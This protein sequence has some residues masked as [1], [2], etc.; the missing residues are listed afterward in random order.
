M[1]DDTERTDDTGEQFFS[2]LFQ[3]S[4]IMM[5]LFGVEDRTFAG[6]NDAFVLRL[7]YLPEEVVG[8]SMSTLGI[9]SVDFERELFAT[10]ATDGRVRDLETRMR[11]KTGEEIITLSSMDV[12]DNKGKTLILWFAVDVT[13][14]VRLR[15]M[16]EANSRELVRSNAELEQFAYVAS[17]DLQEPIRVVTSYLQIIGTQ[18]GAAMDAKGRD[19]I[20]RSIDAANRMQAMI[21]SLLMYSRISSERRPFS[22]IDSAV[23]AQHA[24]QNLCKAIE[25]K[26]ATVRI[27][28]LPKIVA[29]ES[30]FER[31][32]Q[33][34]I[35]NA[36][37]F[38]DKQNPMVLVSATQQSGTTVFSVQDNGLGIEEK[39]FGRIFEIFQRLHSRS[40][41]EGTGIGLAACKKIVERHHGKIWV[42][43]ALGKGSTFYFRLGGVG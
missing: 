31:L 1:I 20:G 23:I 34:L 36:I 28:D 13:E 10:L 25:E 5:S 21:Q 24:V 29:D 37:K 22:T 38:C 12:L 14:T 3:C 30:Q 33:N 43:S 39:H 7:G 41:Y 27:G 9:V 19:F 6:I 40:K 2:Q 17:H 26:K 4:P 35:G 15:E 32:L 16:L 11:S 42:E 18:Y 8:T